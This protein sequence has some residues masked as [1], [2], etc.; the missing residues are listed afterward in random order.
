MIMGA[1]CLAHGSSR[2]LTVPAGRRHGRTMANCSVLDGL[3]MPKISISHLGKDIAAPGKTTALCVSKHRISFHRMRS[4][5]PGSVSHIRC[6]SIP[7][8]GCTGSACTVGVVV[9]PLGGNN[10]AR[11][12]TSRGMKCLCN[13][14]G[15]VSGFIAK[16]GD[17]GL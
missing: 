14:C 7:A 11:L 5:E 13:S 3:V 2:V 1:S 12:S 10:C 16:A 4:L 17:L 9:G 8:K 15:L 6:F